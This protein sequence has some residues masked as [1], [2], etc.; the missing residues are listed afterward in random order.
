MEFKN[1]CEYRTNH[2]RY[3]SV[4]LHAIPFQSSWKEHH[5]TQ[6]SGCINHPEVMCP[7]SGMDNYMHNMGPSSGKKST[8]FGGFDVI[9]IGGSKVFENTTGKCP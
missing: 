8:T 7:L 9:R 3:V 5:N 2:G 6:V 4:V 1:C